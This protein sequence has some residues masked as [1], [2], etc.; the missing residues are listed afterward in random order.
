ML[1]E[2]TGS[3]ARDNSGVA[4]QFDQTIVVLPPAGLDV[5]EVDPHVEVLKTPLLGAL[6]VP[7]LKGALNVSSLARVEHVTLAPVYICPELVMAER[8]WIARRSQRGEDRDDAL[9]VSRRIDGDNAIGVNGNTALTV[10]HAHRG[11]SNCRGLI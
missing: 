4:P 1:H 3:T 11:G 9:V 8:I 7:R 5:T 10:V 2:V 6:D